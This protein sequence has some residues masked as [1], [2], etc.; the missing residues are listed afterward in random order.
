MGGLRRKNSMSR[1]EFL[2]GGGIL[3]AGG[4]IGLAGCVP[5]PQVT[6]ASVS[7]PTWPWPYVRLD[8]EDV[9]KRGHKGYYE[10]A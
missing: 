2:T 9:R 5:P 4:T 7:V 1:R 10:G 3:I 8:V 6:Q